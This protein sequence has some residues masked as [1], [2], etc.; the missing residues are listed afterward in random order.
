MRYLFRFII[1][2][3]DEKIA[4]EL[5]EFGECVLVLHQEGQK[6]VV[7]SE[8]SGSVMGEGHIKVIG[9]KEAKET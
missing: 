6:L 2:L 3:D 7:T 4:R 5:F 9:A 1:D 8:K